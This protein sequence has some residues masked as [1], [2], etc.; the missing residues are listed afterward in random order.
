MVSRK[1]ASCGVGSELE[2]SLCVAKGSTGISVG[3]PGRNQL[4]CHLLL[5]QPEGG[6]EP[7]GFTMEALSILCIIE[8]LK[9]W[10]FGSSEAPWSLM[11]LS[12]WN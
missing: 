4:S 9:K 11:N 3:S 10:W 5:N 6:V 1:M 7:R 8:G 2:T 12:F